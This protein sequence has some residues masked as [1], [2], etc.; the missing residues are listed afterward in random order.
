MEQRYTLNQ[1]WIVSGGDL[2]QNPGER[3]LGLLWDLGSITLPLAYIPV[4]P[5]EG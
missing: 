4:L 5:I 2:A 3:G 1:G